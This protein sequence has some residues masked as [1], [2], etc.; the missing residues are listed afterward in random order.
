VSGGYFGLL[1]GMK[2]W[3]YFV[4]LPDVVLVALYS[5]CNLHKRDFLS[6]HCALRSLPALVRLPVITLTS[7][8]VAFVCASNRHGS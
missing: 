6:G 2:L 5:T 7:A 4:H 1:V 8:I 3:S